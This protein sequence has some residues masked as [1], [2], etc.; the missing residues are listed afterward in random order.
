MWFYFHLCMWVVH[1]GLLLRLPC[2]T[3][4]CP[5]R[6]RGG[7]AAAAWVTDAVAAAGTQGVG[8]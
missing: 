8:S 5:M 1:W 6:A 7:G 4:V 3:W 2:R